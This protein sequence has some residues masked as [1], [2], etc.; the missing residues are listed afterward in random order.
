MTRRRPSLTRP[1]LR[2]GRGHIGRA[3]LALTA[4]LVAGV[5]APTGV[6]A[7]L[8]VDELT[9]SVTELQAEL[10]AVDGAIAEAEA[11]L[12]TTLDDVARLEAEVVLARRDLAAA[13]HRHAESD[14]AL[15]DLAI[16]RYILGDPR[17]E[18]FL[19]EIIQ[20]RASVEPAIE[21]AV[22]A[23]V[24]DSV[25][26]ERDGARD[27]RD[28]LSD[29]LDDRV[30]RLAER[31]SVIPDVRDRIAENL[32]RRETLRRELA[33]V[34]EE[35][36]WEQSL[37]RRARL[38]GRDDGTDN[39]RPV[40]AVKIDNVSAARPQ[41]GIVQADVV[42]EELV[43]GD[44]T[45][46]VA[47]FH[48]TGADPVGPIRSVRTS[49]V[50]ILANLNRPLLANSGG[51][52][53]V[54]ETLRASPVVDVGALSN[55]PGRFFRSPQRPAPNNLM[56]TTADLWAAGVGS[57]AGN[58]PPMFSFRR[59]DRPWGGDA[60]PA[61]GVDIDFG[62]T[63]VGY[64]WDATAG[65][66]LRTQDGSPH[67][68]ATGVQVAPINVIVLTVEY[69]PTA[70]AQ[71]SPEAQVVGEGDVFVFSDGEVRAG[72]WHRAGE[73]EPT[74]YLDA[75]GNEIE[76][77]PGNTWIELAPPGSVRLIG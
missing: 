61:S 70:F 38:T 31:R 46:L 66:W 22:Y 20:E 58:A 6:G 26:D 75:D 2:A 57:E 9:E 33:T 27:L 40:L 30:G 49:D 44:L 1:R 36:D 15:R 17:L 32:D 77:V 11:T 7:Q 10:D 42:F 14:A 39:E 59:P 41:F 55:I 29:T 4:A 54:M 13:T 60:A 37:L 21:R 63:R 72:T 47:L 62:G 43:E 34:Q 18:G 12:A 52:P 64:R 71:F 56:S 3:V 45:R 28:E 53:G 24:L 67:V 51:N 74:R 16:Q 76:I 25:V 48:S 8:D 73:T 19:D 5:V 68:D 69:R 35:L 23:Q 65:G 50:H